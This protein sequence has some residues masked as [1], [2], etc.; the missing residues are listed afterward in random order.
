[1]YPAN[2]LYS[3]IG[4]ENLSVDTLGYFIQTVIS[5][6]IMKAV[7]LPFQT[8]PVLFQSLLLQWWPEPLILLCVFFCLLFMM[9]SWCMH[10]CVIYNG[11]LIFWGI[12]LYNILWGLC[13]GTLLSLKSRGMICICFYQVPA[14]VLNFWVIFSTPS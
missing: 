6:Q 1:M 7:I 3:S 10:V 5:P 8:V 14:F 4:A 2:L 12:L 13:E 9:P 11:E